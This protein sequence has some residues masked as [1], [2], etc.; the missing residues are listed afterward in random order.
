MGRLLFALTACL[1][2]LA[3]TARAQDQGVFIQLEANRSQPDALQNVSDYADLFEN[4]AG[5]QAP[6]GWYVTTLGP[7]AP[8]TAR[9]ELRRLR[10]LGVIPLDSFVQPRT[11]YGA[12]FFPDADAGALRVTQAQATAPQTAETSPAPV[13]PVETLAQ[14]RAAERALSREEKQEIQRALAE[15]GYYTAGI[16]GA[17]GPG[18]RRGIQGWQADRGFEATG[19]L[20]TSQQAALLREYNAVFDGLGLARVA[21]PRAGLAMELPL[22]VLSR[23]RVEPPFVVYTASGSLP[24]QVLLISQPG[25]RRTL[26]GLYEIMQTLEIV[27][28]A[29][30][31]DLTARGFTITGANNEI[32]SHTEVTLADGAIKGFT[33]VW[34]AGDERRRGRVLDRM[35]DSLEILPG[36]LDPN[37]LGADDAASVDLV[38]GLAVRKPIR[39]ASGFFVDNRGRVVTHTDTVAGCTRVTVN[40]DID[41]RVIA[42]DSQRGITLLEPVERLAPRQIAA[43]RDGLP[44]LQSEVAVAGFSFGG[45]LGAPSV[46]YGQVSDHGGLNGEDG[47]S[48]LRLSARPG[49]AGGP[50]LDVA[51]QVVGMLVPEG[52]AGGRVLP[53]DVRFAADQGAILGLM[54]TAGVPAATQSAGT[55]LDPVDLAR[56]ASDMTVLVGCWD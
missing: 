3:A 37:T 13:E 36:M 26:A 39:S 42:E 5:F 51:G 43:F 54:R 41:T 21:D 24:V 1:S 47:I 38:A 32:V 52:D 19:V 34:P 53:E 30:E 10:A 55:R 44:R 25:D 23:D 45:T 2:L 16:D 35:R 40:G 11:F 14:S 56:L 8:D 29:G 31:R 4:V 17:F 27:P 49:D 18:T 9:Q 28:L 12:R 33:L 15:Q 6:G 46:T 7:F 48:R 22:D 20:S 50:I